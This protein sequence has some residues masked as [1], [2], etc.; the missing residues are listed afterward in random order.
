[1]DRNATSDDYMKAM[2][3]MTPLTLFTPVAD[4]IRRTAQPPAR[5]G[6]IAGSLLELAVEAESD[7]VFASGL[8]PTRLRQAFRILGVQ[9]QDDEPRIAAR[10]TT[11]REI[12]DALAAVHQAGD[13]SPLGPDTRWW[14]VP[15]CWTG[16]DQRSLAI[17]ET[18]AREY[19]ELRAA[20][21]AT[22][23]P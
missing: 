22:G 20:D 10:R 21:R 14:L 15:M 8:D 6:A 9:R 11:C 12:A 17:R 3:T 7:P 16:T 4:H 2:T 5:A 13:A 1:L 23:A 19:D 18:G